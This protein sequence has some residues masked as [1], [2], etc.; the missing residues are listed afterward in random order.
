M[1]R[2]LK[3]TVSSP[4]LTSPA[5]PSSPLLLSVEDAAR[6]LGVSRATT[7]TLLQRKQLRS[8][9]VGARRLIPRAAL[10]EWIEQQLAAQEPGS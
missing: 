10:T 5:A 2:S 8:L 4:A 7:Y 3:S 1:E 9:K 6:E